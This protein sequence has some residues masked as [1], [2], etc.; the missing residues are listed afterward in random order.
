MLWYYNNQELLKIIINIFLDRVSPRMDVPFQVGP[1]V[2][3][4]NG[5]R[6]MRPVSRPAPGQS[7][8]SVLQVCSLTGQARRYA[9][10]DGAGRARGAGP[11]ATSVPGI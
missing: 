7:S 1:A 9:D 8:I 5:Q 4:A 11:G 3:P 6:G 10:P 2:E